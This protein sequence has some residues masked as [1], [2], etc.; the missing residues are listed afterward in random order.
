MLDLNV[1][2]IF[3]GK[4]YVTLKAESKQYFYWNNCRLAYFSVS[5]VYECLMKFSLN[6]STGLKGKVWHITPAPWLTQ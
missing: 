4:K 2:K 6:Q 1:N 5:Y 3:C